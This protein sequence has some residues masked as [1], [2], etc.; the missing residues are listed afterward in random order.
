MFSLFIAAQEP[1]LSCAPYWSLIFERRIGF[2]ISL[3]WP[4]FVD[5]LSDNLIEN[6]RVAED[7]DNYIVRSVTLRR[8]G[9]SHNV[10]HIFFKC[11]PDKGVPEKAAFQPFISMLMRKVQPSDTCL[12]HCRVFLVLICLVQESVELEL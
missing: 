2:F 10:D 12:L 3:S 11:W 5:I 4:S 6:V 9:I 7:T 1:H 8:E